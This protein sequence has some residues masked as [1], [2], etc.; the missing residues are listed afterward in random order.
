MIRRPPRSTRTPTLFPYTTL[1][2]SIAAE[3]VVVLRQ[4]QMAGCC[5]LAS[6]FSDA[7]LTSKELPH[8][9]ARPSQPFGR[10][11]GTWQDITHGESIADVRPRCPTGTTDHA[12]VV[13]VATEE[14]PIT[15]DSLIRDM[16]VI[17]GQDDA[18]IL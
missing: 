16:R 11:E 17:C 15:R 18:R 3:G 7:A 5:G 8:Y 12:A 13:L 1:F 2:R 6:R 14:M 10:D 4:L 9:A